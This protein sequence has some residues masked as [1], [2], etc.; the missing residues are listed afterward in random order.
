MSM[1]E[2]D[3]PLYFPE[4]DEPSPS[5]GRYA[6][7]DAQVAWLARSSQPRAA[8]IR[9]F[10]NASLSALPVDAADNLA[11][12]LR[13]DPPFQSVFFELIVGRF[14]QVLGATVEHQPA[15]VGGSNVDWRATFAD[16]STILVE[17]TSPEYNRDAAE[18]R[19]RREALVGVI[20]DEAPRGWWIHPVQLPS[21]GVDDSRREYR[22]LVRSLLTNLPDPIG[23]SIEERLRRAGMTAQGPLELELWPGDWRDSPIAMVSMGAHRDDSALRVAVAARAK[24]RQARA[25]PGEIVLV[26][27]DAPF[28]GPDLEDFDTALFGQTV[29]HI[30]RDRGVLGTSFRASGVL[31]RQRAVEY[32][33]VLAFGRVSVFGVDDPTLYRHPLFRSEY[34]LPLLALR[35]RMLEASMIVDVPASRTGIC[36]RIGLPAAGDPSDPA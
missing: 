17:A 33:G 31:A 23:Y 8:R 21:I 13:R 2:R 36:E 16:G 9:A 26:A 30:G 14:L 22:K 27:L 18:E 15:G 25:Y 24:R 3:R 19:R 1:A 7:G 5:W 10:L 11:H 32:A 29:V 6:D 20:E 34:P 4:P 35:R 28:V 12:R